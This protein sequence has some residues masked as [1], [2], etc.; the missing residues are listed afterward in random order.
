MKRRGGGQTH[1]LC[2]RR[3]KKGSNALTHCATF[4]LQRAHKIKEELTEIRQKIYLSLG[5]SRDGTLGPSPR[6][7]VARP[8]ITDAIHNGQL[9]KVGL[10][11]CS[12]SW[13]VCDGWLPVEALDNGARRTPPSLGEHA[14][15]TVAGHSEPLGSRRRFAAGRIAGTNCSWPRRLTSYVA[16]RANPSSRVDLRGTLLEGC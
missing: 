11:V 14:D 13:C 4:F 8:S 16:M 15:P 7:L 1:V 10:W 3:G 12:A 9:P 5:L 6:S 2:A